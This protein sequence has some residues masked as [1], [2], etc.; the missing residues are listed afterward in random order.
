[1]TDADR[2]KAIEAR[3]RNATPGPWRDDCGDIVTDNLKSVVAFTDTDSIRFNGN[4]AFI[5]NAPDDIEWLLAHIGDL[6]QEVADAENEDCEECQ[7]REND[8]DRDELEARIA[9]YETALMKIADGC[10]HPH[11]VA[12]DAL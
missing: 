4:V 11:N 10:K 8:L 1:M 9:R 6:E 3:L 2:L 7:E 12:K 5:A